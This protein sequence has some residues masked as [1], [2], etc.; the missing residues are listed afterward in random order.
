MT[1]PRKY[2]P[3]IGA[4]VYFNSGVSGLIPCEVMALPMDCHWLRG[5]VG[6]DLRVIEARPCYK[7]GETI[8]GVGAPVVVP[9]SAVTQEKAGPAIRAFHWIKTRGL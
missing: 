8:R 6:F 2:R 1:K 4:R 9:M 7:A 3:A 5:G